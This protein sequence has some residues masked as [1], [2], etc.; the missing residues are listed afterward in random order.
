M[1]AAPGKDKATKTCVVE[2]VVDC[3]FIFMLKQL[4]TRST[5]IKKQ[6]QFQA[7]MEHLSSIK[8]IGQTE[9]Y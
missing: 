2:V 8:I 6:E 7:V 5:Y 1:I 3:I 9:I 4:T